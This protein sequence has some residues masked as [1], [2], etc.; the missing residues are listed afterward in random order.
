MWYYSD[1]F[2]A[3][4]K[5]K[6]KKKE[7]D[8]EREIAVSSFVLCVTIPKL[9]R[10]LPRSAYTSTSVNVPRMLILLTVSTNKRYG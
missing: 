3:K 2:V 1:S 10:I 9:P 5:T 7:I 8:T 4:K 6:G